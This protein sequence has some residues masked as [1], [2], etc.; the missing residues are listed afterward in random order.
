MISLLRD[1]SDFSEF[2]KLIAVFL[3][4]FIV[5]ED[6]DILKNRKSL[7]KDPNLSKKNTAL[8]KFEG[9]LIKMQ[10]SELKHIEVH[11]PYLY[12]VLTN[13]SSSTTSAA[14]S[15]SSSSSSSNLNSG[16]TSDNTASS[17]A[18]PHPVLVGSY[19]VWQ[20]MF[21][22]ITSSSLMFLGIGRM[23]RSTLI[24]ALILSR[25]YGIHHCHR[26]Y[27]DALFSKSSNFQIYEML[28]LCI[29]LDPASLSIQY[30]F[31]RVANHYSLEEPSKLSPV[32]IDMMSGI[33]THLCYSSACVDNFLLLKCVEYMIDNMD[34]VSKQLNSN[35]TLGIIDLLHI[36]L[37]K[38]FFS[39]SS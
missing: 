38:L 10:C 27:C 21:S 34:S 12:E 39:R 36:A 1:L 33:K 15:S 2:L 9:K 24:E 5:N 22:H 37:Y 29:S 28:E 6:E 11:S 35:K 4:K 32:A 23:P 13:S 18:Y 20:E 16:Y 3:T 19:S 25:V 17:K 30:D 7:S 8:V 14:A 26:S 31:A